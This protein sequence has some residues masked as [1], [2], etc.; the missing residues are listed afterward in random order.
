MT[1]KSPSDQANSS[2]VGLETETLVAL[3][4]ARALNQADQP[5]YSFLLDE[6]DNACGLTFGEL[7]SQ[8]RA[9]AGLLQSLAPGGEPILLLY[10]PGI[11]YISAFFGCL[12]AGMVAVPT[13]P[14]RVN[15]TLPR[16]RSIALDALATIALTTKKALLKM[17]S[18]GAQVPELES[19]KYISTDDIPA[20]LAKGWKPPK[21]YG[22]AVA[23]LQYTSGSTATPKGVM[24][25]HSNLLNN[26]R[27][28]Q[29]AFKQTEQSI[30]VGWLPLYHDMGLIGNVI[31]PLFTGAHCI[32]MS[33]AAFLQKPL[34]WLQAISR[35]KATTSGGPNFAYDLCVRK[36]KPEDREGLDL[37]SWTVAFNG[38][39]PI[40]AQTLRRFTEAFVSCGFRP[41]T[42]CPCYGLAEATLMVTGK[43][44]L[45]SPVIKRIHTKSL[46][47]GRAVE[48]QAS[49]KDARTLVSSGKTLPGQKVIIVDPQSMTECLGGEV[50]EI[51]V[52]GPS[53][54]A[55][56]WNRPDQSRYTFDAHVSNTGEGP[57]LRTG[58]LGFIL[59]GELF[60]TGRLKDLIII[61]G[62]N[63]YPQ[64]IELTVEETHT[65]LRR[66]CGA[67]FS[68]EIGD[69]EQVVVVQEVD[70]HQ[71]HLDIIV[72]LICKSVAQTHELQL[73]AVVLIKPGS[74]PKT[75]SGKIQ[76]HACREDFLRGKLEALAEW[77]A[78]EGA[79][80]GAEATYLEPAVAQPSLG[81]EAIESWLVS[82]LAERLK[83]KT[84]SI[85]VNRPLTHLGL[86]SLGMVDIAHA[87]EAATGVV[88]SISTLLEAPSISQLAAHLLAKSEDAPA[89]SSLIPAR[90]EVTNNSLSKGQQ[91]L[92]FLY[93]LKPDNNAYIIAAAA[94][95]KG[96]LNINAL[97][98]SFQ[99]LVDRHG[100]LRTS[101][102]AVEGKPAQRIEDHIDFKLAEEDAAKW[103]EQQVS[104]WLREESLRCF[105]LETA[106]L[107]RVQ[108]L[109]RTAREYI[110]LL[111]AH[112]IIIDMWS[113]V[114]MLSELGNLYSAALRGDVAELPPQRLQ[115]RD[116]V[117]WQE[118]MLESPEAQR[119]WSYWQR[120]LS[121]DL[122]PLNIITDR[123]RPPL[124]T[125]E[126]ASH[127]FKVG[128]ELTDKLGSLG[129]SHRATMYMTLLA[130][131][132]ALLNRYTE[133]QDIL[134]GSP[135][136]GRNS[137]D[138]AGVVGYFVNPVVLRADFTSSPNFEELINQTRRVVLEA[139]EHQDYP[140]PLLVERLQPVREPSR[141]PLFQVMFAL[142]SSH[143]M[144]DENL[145]A[146]SLGEAGASINIGG[147]KLESLALDRRSSQFDLFLMMA[148]SD[149]GISASMQYN[150]DLFDAASI[151]RMATHYTAMLEAAAADP[152]RPISELQMLSQTE[153][154]QLL[155]E[156]NDTGREYSPDL[157]IHH[158][159]EAQAE[160]T[161]EAIALAFENE[162]ITYKELNARANQLAHY[163]KSLSVGPETPVGICLPRSIEMVVA[164]LGILKAGGAYVPLDPAYPKDRLTFILRDSNALL[165]LT[166]R[167]FVPEL[168][169]SSIKLISL[170]AEGDRLAKQS[171]TNLSAGVTPKNLAYAIYTSGSTGRPKG[172]AI[173][174]RSAVAFLCWAREVFNRESLAGVLA[175]TSICFD[176]S[177]FELFAPLSTGATVILG[178]N[179]LQLPALSAAR[180]VTLINTVPSA[181]QELMRIEGVPAS[182]RVVNLAGEPLR[183]SLVQEIYETGHI[184]KVYNLYGPSEDTTYSLYALLCKGSQQQP[185]IGRPIA[186]TQAYL[187][188]RQLQPLPTGVPGELHLSGDG[189]ARGYINR[190][191]ITAE[192]FIPNPFGNEAGARLYKTGDLARYLPNGE[193]EFLGRI[194]HQVKL[195]GYRIELGEIEAVLSR[196]H[197]VYDKVVIADDDGHGGKRLIAY[198][199]RKPG[200][201]ITQKDLRTFLKE[202][203]PEYMIPVAFVLMDALP[204]T[205]NGKVDRR[206]LPRPSEAMEEREQAYEAPKTAV[207]KMLAEIWSELLGAGQVGIH[208]NFFDLRGHS[209]LATQV[210]A[211]VRKLYGLDLGLQRIFEMPTIAQLSEEIE[212]LKAES[213]RRR[214]PRIKALPREKYLANAP[215][216]QK[217]EDPAPPKD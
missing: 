69:D 174:H 17:H 32:L 2:E 28:I 138:L 99:A 94:R 49:D 116:Y 170:D 163:L 39:E 71:D 66:G 186:N 95:I 31:Q 8:A 144:R 198:I 109:K 12:Y 63:H 35:Y 121:G 53:V 141:S 208:D 22:N 183:N 177:V 161:P 61:R 47:S 147:F 166:E 132:Q 52:S 107:L 58:D 133:Q 156:W 212:K 30:I 100:S 108:L 197:A 137:A 25:T 1:G 11:E 77:R 157:C 55:G 74:I 205:P 203:L 70:H 129:Q 85:D 38:A 130:G 46:E 101:F 118:E 128:A 29:S 18:L 160:R 73:N 154:H 168:Q 143:L 185:P 165:L 145:A 75:S 190:Q 102:P 215:S 175:S 56:Y 76:R 140:F 91:A 159:F 125:Y 3:L 14:P 195:R 180:E 6:E 105:N 87:V 37:S 164:M 192:A 131:F 24:L 158:L 155:V 64:D 92:W 96:D 98:S 90:R 207:E 27:L 26:E 93:E 23:L 201:E 42:F 115:Y 204:L 209:L 200:T 211:K 191:E 135:T 4:Q 117:L 127:S 178:E 113:L 54:A 189:L 206:K 9:I 83:I 40:R 148:E 43:Q 162:R 122:P 84:S 60:V 171:E 51:W 216:P 50:G 202:S 149:D 59:D 126:G 41:E 48:Q 5:A 112:H 81:D 111:T 88:L 179:I 72:D 217:P 67:A 57:F 104:K 97:Q 199:V 65:S 15:R 89:R 176:L 114:V 34:R 7:D 82:K 214:T 153:L 79:A 173:E 20:N 68:V 123:P 193:M 44:A 120:Q 150:V 187:L 86:D 142:Q 181:M 78:A 62:V 16:F 146:F 152:R 167:E 33:P 21:T 134:L 184:E 182:V 124:Q 119:L 106:P 194:D 80:E 36:I 210:V 196:H 139:F 110:L 13:Y 169:T 188:N 10:P 213:A 19:L 103:S 172:V 136:S 151:E 45:D